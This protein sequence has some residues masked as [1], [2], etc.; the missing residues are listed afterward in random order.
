MRPH[1]VL[2]AIAYTALATSALA[3]SPRQKPDESW[4]KP[5]TSYLQY[6]TD[7]VECA[8]KV[9]QEA[10]VALP[11]VDLTFPID[12]PNTV[13][14]PG[15]GDRNY[16]FDVISAFDAAKARM[17]PEWRK[18]TA[19]VFP[20]LSQCLMDRGYQRFRLTKDQT[21]QLKALPAGSKARHTYL[22]NLAVDPAIQQRQA[23]LTRR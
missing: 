20:A 14:I 18:V 22:W 7:A 16:V 15:Y 5:G 11:L 21:E 19:Q 13:G 10:P 3:D 1:L 6:R 23:I 4:G 8:Y 17:A 2:T 12:M 9:G